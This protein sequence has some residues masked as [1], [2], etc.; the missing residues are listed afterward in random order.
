M[1]MHVHIGKTPKDTKQKK[2]IIVGLLVEI[3]IIVEVRGV[4]QLVRVE[5]VAGVTYQYVEV[6]QPISKQIYRSGV[7]Q[8]CILM[9]LKIHWN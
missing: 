8:I 9:H 6:R 3:V 5:V 1:D 2:K 7:N 4:I